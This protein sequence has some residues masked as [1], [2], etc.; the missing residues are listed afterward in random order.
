NITAQPSPGSPSTLLMTLAPGATA[1][2]DLRWVSG[3]VYDNGHCEF[4]AYVMLQIGEQTLFSTFVGHVCG[5]GGKPSTYTLTS[6]QPAETPLPV[7]ATSPITY[8]CDDG[9]TVQATYPNANSA[10]IT[11]DGQN[12]RLHTVIAASGVRYVDSHWQWW[13]KGLKHA[14]LA[15]LKPGETIASASG[16][17]CSAT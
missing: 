9:R 12:R 6:F 7:S 5:A 4:P 3:D 8:T 10:V 11:L 17:A 14:Q 1:S 15:P 16:V 13:S 2:S